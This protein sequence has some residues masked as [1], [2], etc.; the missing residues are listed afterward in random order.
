MQID[1]IKMTKEEMNRMVQ[2]WLE[3]R[4]IK[5][6]VENVVTYGYPTEGFKIELKAE[7]S[8]EQIPAPQPIA[9]K[10]HKM[11]EGPAE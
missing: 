7:V 5:V 3:W 6:E 2:S 4:G 11:T 1:E 8:D 10:V 9:R